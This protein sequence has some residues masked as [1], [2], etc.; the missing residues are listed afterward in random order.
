M[1]VAVLSVLLI[2][3]CEESGSGASI[4]SGDSA[5]PASRPLGPGDLAIT[6]TDGAV[7]LVLQSDTIWMGLA[8]SIVRKVR[9][10]LATSTA[11]DRDTGGLGGTIASFVKSTVGREIND[12][13]QIP[14][15]DV[16]HVSYEDG[17]IK[18]RFR[19]GAQ[20]TI[21]VLGKRR[22]VDFDKP[23]FHYGKDDSDHKPVL[24][25]FSPADADA[26]V[27]AVRAAK[28]QSS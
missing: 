9:H 8:D 28:A 1:S 25:S 21:S 17:A 23:G 11:G 12:R 7:Q 15:A 3:G 26:F 13:I 10:D 6:T 18:F 14:L 27:K 24:E 20:P 22:T 4:S 16:E 2:G 19:E 5:A